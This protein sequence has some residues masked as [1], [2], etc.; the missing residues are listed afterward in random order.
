MF[1]IRRTRWIPLGLVMA[2]LLLPLPA[3]A[4]GLWETASRDWTGAWMGFFDWLGSVA[5][6]TSCVMIDPDGCPSQSTTP[7]SPGT[8]S[9][10]MID[11]LGCLGHSTASGSPDNS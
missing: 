3:S 2:V 9:C 10:A 1:R 4:G 7:G 8:E 5:V 6:Q 11:P